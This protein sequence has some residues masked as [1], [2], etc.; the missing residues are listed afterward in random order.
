[1]AVKPDAQLDIPALKKLLERVRRDIHQ[2]HNDVRYAMNGFVISAA[3]YIQPL[4]QFAM[5]VAESIGRV[6][7]DM[8]DTA[9]QVPYAPEYIRKIEARGTIGKKRKSARC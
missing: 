8:G 9:C 2:A 5:E 6:E 1:M 3:A 7:V 4:T